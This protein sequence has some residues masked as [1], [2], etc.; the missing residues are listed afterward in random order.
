[1]ININ[2]KNFNTDTKAYQAASFAAKT[3]TCKIALAIEEEHH[4]YKIFCMNSARKQITDCKG[5]VDKIKNN[6]KDLIVI[7]MGGS[8]LNP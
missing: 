2:Y 3:A 8:V 4:S 7:G 1:M 5:I 6:F